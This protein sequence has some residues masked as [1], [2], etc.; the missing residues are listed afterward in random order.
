MSSS[1][2]KSRPVY[3][4]LTPDPTARHHLFVVRSDAV[5][6]ALRIARLLDDTSASLAFIVSGAS[7]DCADVQER[8]RLVGTAC[9][10]YLHDA[11][12]LEA[13]TRCLAA[14][15]MGTRLYLAGSEGFLASCVRIAESSGLAADEI[16][17]ELI[18]TLARPVFCV[19]CRTVTPR[20]TTNIAPCSGCGRMLLVRDHFS[21]RLAAFMGVQADAE[22]PGSLPERVD[23]FS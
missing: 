9:E 4:T 11:D 13:L 14:A 22:V 18:G 19:H 20:V 8:L 16:R 10:H 5:A 1:A 23:L 7:D 3:G 6:P 2:N 12:A 15:R 17:C 21:R